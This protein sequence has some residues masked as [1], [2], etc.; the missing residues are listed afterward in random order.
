MDRDGLDA[1]FMAR[2]VD[3]QRDLA[4]VG[5]QQFLDSHRVRLS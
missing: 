1:H 5:D 4:A 2:A 3:A